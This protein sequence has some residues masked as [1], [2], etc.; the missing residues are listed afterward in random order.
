MNNVLCNIQQLFE[1][2]LHWNL[3]LTKHFKHGSADMV[4]QRSCGERS[5]SLQ[6]RKHAIM[7]SKKKTKNTVPNK[8]KN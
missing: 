1:N 6:G 8:L 4:L 2:I 5:R 7:V 3:Q